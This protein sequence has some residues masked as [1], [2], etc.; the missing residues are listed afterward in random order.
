M[1]RCPRNKVFKSSL[2]ACTFSALFSHATTQ[3]NELEEIMVTSQK[4]SLSIQEVAGSVIALPGETIEEMGVENIEDLTALAPNIHLTETGISTQLRIRGIGSDNSQGFEQ[5]VGVFVDG[6][7]RGRAQLLRAPIFDLERVEIAR[8]PQGTLFGKNTIAGA[9]DF[10]TAKPTSD[11][12]GELAASYESEF[13]TQETSGFVSGPFTE[14]FKGRL[15]FRHYD[16]PGYM[17]NTFKED[18]EPEQI[19]SSARLSLDWQPNA[20]ASISFTT[21]KHELDLTGRAIEITQ[22]EPGP[23]GFTYSQALASENNGITFD[24]ELDY[25]RQSNSDEESINNI[26]SSTLRVDYDW[27]GTTITLISGLLNYDY[28]E[29]CDCD[30]TPADIFEL[31]LLEEYKQFSHEIR[32]VSPED[33]KVS[34]IAGFFMQNYE[35]DFTDILVVNPEPVFLNAVPIPNVGPVDFGG[36]GVMRNFAQDSNAKSLYGEATWHATETMRVTLG[37]RYTEEQKDATKELN[38]IE[39]TNNN[40]V[41]A[42]P[43]RAGL[44]GRLYLGVFSTETQQSVGHSLDESRDESAFSPSLSVS[45]DVS[46]DVMAY[47]KVSR[48]F[49]AGGFDPRSNN[50]ANFE[51][52]DEHVN[53]FEIGYKVRLNEGRGEVNTTFFRMDYKDLQVSQFDGGVGFNVGNAD[54]QS[55]GIEI[56]GRWKLTDHLRAQYSLAY[57]DFEYTDFKTGNCHYPDTTNNILICDVTGERGVYTPEFT[58]NS[59][60]HYSRSIGDGLVVSSTFDMQWVD[61]QQV[62]VNLDPKGE[63]DAYA[64][65]NYRIGLEADHWSIALL[66]K[67]LLD[68][69]VISYSA[70]VPLSD[71]EDFARSNT[72]Y[73]FVRRPRTFT[74]EGALRF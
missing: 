18:D 62:H 38:V 47:G 5:S 50:T 21:E 27:D 71:G 49:K 10:I 4:R 72:Y 51:F 56:D 7:F 61:K 65:L 68:E 29:N 60:L 41:I 70:N 33:Q 25:K 48:G 44:Y 22:D 37:A 74:I 53:S 3:A 69:E 30:F 16:D 14:Q 26:S 9:I 1:P 15:A 17:E 34:W 66:A 35:Q 32:F 6:V 64:L 31:N 36:T 2:F 13:G 55:Q 12:E 28:D 54:A 63:I 20:D 19:E 67:N 39:P 46:D 24:S 52:E 11:W 58:L 23:P 43:I 45:I 59:A 42:D 57:L 8:G 40:A 73:S